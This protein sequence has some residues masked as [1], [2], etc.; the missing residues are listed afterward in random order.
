MNYNNLI[1]NIEMTHNVLQSSV[2]KAINRGLTVR[3]WLI[4]FYI[5]EFEQKGQDRANYGDQLLIE[6]S[7]STKINGL[8]VTNLKTFRQFYKIY[9]SISQSISDFFKENPIGQTVS[10]QFNLSI[11]QTLSDQFKLPIIKSLTDEFKSFDKIGIGPNKI[12][13]KLS[14][15]HL[16]EL[17]KIEDDLKRAFYELECTKG[18][19][20]VRELKRQIESLYFERSGIS[21]DK[22][23]LSEYV[24][25]KATHLKPHHI[26]NSPFSVEFLGLSDRA[27]VTESDL[28][29]ALIENLQHFLLEMGNG[30]CFESRQKRI[31][32]DDEYYFVDLVFYNRIL[33]CHVIIELKTEKFKHNHA[34][35]LNFYL[36]YFKE[37]ITQ[38]DD[39]PPVGILLCTEKGETTVKY[40]TAGIKEKI[41]VQKY[42]INLPSKEELADYLNNLD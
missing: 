28:E 38:K 41:F 35:Q 5:V 12:I 40:A 15:S 31:L 39:N 14:F 7:K 11:G 37:E 42:M 6:I 20:S 23:K 25:E 3:N 24:N 27:I 33:K 29:Q 22:A 18:V 1:Q 16:V 36:N 2:A 32:I 9:P 30:F 26:I 19:W 13:S 21:K 17:L 10:D 4:G 8:S 34:S